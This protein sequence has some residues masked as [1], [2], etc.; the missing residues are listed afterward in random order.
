MQAVGLAMW[1]C[2][3]QGLRE[4]VVGRGDVGAQPLEI[5]CSECNLQRLRGRVEK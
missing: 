1:Q 2:K 5:A 3:L 4:G